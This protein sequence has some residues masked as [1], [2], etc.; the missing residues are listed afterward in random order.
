MGVDSV[1]SGR[2]ARDLAALAEHVSASA[3]ID[4]DDPAPLESPIPPVGRLTRDTPG[5]TPVQVTTAP[6]RRPPRG[7]EPPISADPAPPP[8]PPV[9]LS[10][11]A[12]AEPNPGST[13]RRRKPVTDTLV[14]APAPADV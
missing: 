1:P 11:P 12:I 14:D 8:A 4:R 2:H 3:V 10:P 5:A 6:G 7:A 9:I 13:G